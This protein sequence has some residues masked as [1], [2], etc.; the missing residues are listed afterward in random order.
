M[1]TRDYTAMSS[2]DVDFSESQHPP[3]RV[4]ASSLR[5]ELDQHRD[6]RRRL[7]DQNPP[8]WT[9]N[10]SALRGVHEC[11]NLSVREAIHKIAMQEDTEAAESSGSLSEGPG[12]CRP[13]DLYH[14]I[15]PS[16]AYPR[17]FKPRYEGHK[18][19]GRLA[20]ISEGFQRSSKP[21]QVCFGMVS[22]FHTSTD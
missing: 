21:K 8:H 7:E 5:Y 2:L 22:A 3:S 18:R 9:N 20:G 1:E 17:N 16:T 11:N 19:E 14:A 4:E 13:R 15:H 6:K 12:S 10:A